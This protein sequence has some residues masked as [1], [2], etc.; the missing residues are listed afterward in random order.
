MSSF[1]RVKNIKE[2]DHNVSPYIDERM[3]SYIGRTF[4]VLDSSFSE[5]LGKK[6]FSL[7]DNPFYWTE[8][9]LEFLPEVYKYESLVRLD[10]EYKA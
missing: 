4:D 6:Y 8:D 5:E 2:M 7:K 3:Y 9:W 1:V 10:K